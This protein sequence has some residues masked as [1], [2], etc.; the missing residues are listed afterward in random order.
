MDV[1]RP[2][3]SKP[4]PGARLRAAW[5]LTSFGIAQIAICAIAAFPLVMAWVLLLQLP[6]G[7]GLV[8][9]SVLS[10]AI[11]LSYAVFAMVLMAVSAL[12]TGA[13]GWRTPPDAALRIA[14]LD[15]P[16]LDWFRNV[17]SIRVVNA[18]AGV[19]YC[20]SPIW[21]AYLRMNG[22]RIGRR[23]Y[24]NSLSVSDHNLLDF[25]DDVIIGADVHLS[26]HTVEGGF[27]KTGYVRLG[28]GV[29]IGL[30]SI[31]NID[32][33]AGDYC[34]VGA[35]SLVPKHSRLEAGTLYVG[36]PVRHVSKEPKG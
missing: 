3:S 20:G 28:R 23:V 5:A 1:E 16:A 2:L 26:G 35:L 19:L 14:E 17:S 25:G 22:A 10:L 11:P 15:W 32:V 12:V 7:D 6:L 8:R 27:V 36:V 13:L 24:I 33:Q 21:T 18:L 30:G 29:T 31:V 4:T 9:A 34:Q